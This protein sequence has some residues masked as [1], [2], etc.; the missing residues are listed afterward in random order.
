[1]NAR[2]LLASLIVAGLACGVAQSSSDTQVSQLFVKPLGDIPGKEALVLRVSY[3]PGGKD[4][5]HRHDAHAF[6]YVLEGTIR[7]QLKGQPEKT[8]K[9]GEV[10][11]EGPDDVHM[12]G[13]NASETDPATFVVVLIKKQ[14]APV[15]TPVKP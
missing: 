8:V 2:S 11:Y 10:F 7:M 13:R 6:V 3:P 5:I 9:A 1:M 12:V 14:G 15:L 4:E